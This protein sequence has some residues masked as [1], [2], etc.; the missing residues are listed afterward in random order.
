MP[1]LHQFVPKAA[2]PLVLSP[3]ETKVVKKSCGITSIKLVLSLGANCQSGCGLD[4]RWQYKYPPA[5]PPALHH[6]GVCPMRRFVR[7]STGGGD[8]GVPR[9]SL[10]L[11]W[12]RTENPTTGCSSTATVS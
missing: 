11:I 10:N 4:I 8:G 6:I 3:M 1:C 5:V 9:P 12:S 7:F 2:R